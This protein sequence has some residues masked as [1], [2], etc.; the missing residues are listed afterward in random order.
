MSICERCAY[1]E[2]KRTSNGRLHPSKKGA[3]CYSVPI[4][5]LPICMTS[6]QNLRPIGGEIYRNSL[7]QNYASCPTFLPLVEMSK[8]EKFKSAKADFL[9]A[10]EV[11][12]SLR[13]TKGSR[14]ELTSLADSACC[15]F[16]VATHKL[17]E[18]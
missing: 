1:A 11:V 5:A 13:Y 4:P 8:V 2:W 18:K 15:E 16:I 14:K 9:D 12:F 17:L 7:K 3:C 6:T 10:M